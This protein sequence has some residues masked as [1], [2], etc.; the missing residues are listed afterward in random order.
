MKDLLVVPVAFVISFGT[1]AQQ[2]QDN[3]KQQLHNY[4]CHMQIENGTDVV[5]DYYDQPLNQNNNLQRMLVRDS[6]ML[7]RGVRMNIVKVHECVELDA[8][9]SKATAREL[10]RNTLR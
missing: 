6:I 7:N 9:F 3:S 4:K 5:R 2:T 10:D 8:E 1:Y